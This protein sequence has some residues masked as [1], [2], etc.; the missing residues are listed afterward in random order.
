M[1]NTIAS[2]PDFEA[3]GGY[4]GFVLSWGSDPDGDFHAEW[5]AL[6]FSSRYI[7][8]RKAFG[9]HVASEALPHEQLLLFDANHLTRLGNQPRKSLA[10]RE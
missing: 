9:H 5:N 7:F 10:F 1:G 8:L 4:P 3:A 2:A 6:I